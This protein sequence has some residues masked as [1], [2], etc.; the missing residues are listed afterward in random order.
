MKQTRKLGLL[1]A[2]FLLLASTNLVT[3][4][5]S[6]ITVGQE[7][8]SSFP[9]ITSAPTASFI[10]GV[11]STFEA[12]TTAQP[13]ASFTETGLLPNGVTLSLGGLLVGTPASGT[14]GVYPITIYASNGVGSPA[15]QNFTLTV[16]PIEMQTTS[17][18]AGEFGV[19]YS[20]TLNAVGGYPPYKWSLISGVKLPSGLKL[21]SK[22]GVISGVPKVV[23]TFS[24]SVQVAD[25]KTK[26]KPPTQDKTSETFTMTISPRSVLTFTNEPG[27]GQSGTALP[28]QP[29]VNVEN[30]SGTTVGSSTAAVT[31]SVATGAGSISCASNPVTAVDGV[32]S[33]A[34]C[35]ISG[36]AGT[37]T[38]SASSPGLLGAV[39]GKFTISAGTPN[40]LVF[41]T[42]PGSDSNGQDLSAQPTVTVEDASGN[43]VTSATNEIELSVAVGSGSLVCASD[44]VA[45]VDGIANFT[46]CRITGLV[47]QFILTAA[48][49]RLAN[50][51]SSPVMVTSG[52]AS[53]LVFSTE[54][55]TGQSGSALS[56][57]P[58]VTVEDASG[59][60]VANSS[61]PITLSVGSGAGS[62]TCSAN[63]VSAIDGIATFT[64]CSIA[65]SPGAYNLAASATGV[66]Q[67][68]ASPITV[69]GA[70]SQ[71]VFSTEPGNGQSGSALSVQPVVTVEDASGNTVTNSSL[72]ITLSVGS[73]AGSVT[74]SA[75]PVS[76]IDG[77]ATFTGCSIAGSPG[78]Y[79]LAASA[80]GVSQATASP[81]TVFG[82]ASQLVFST[83]PVPV[84]RVRSVRS[85]GRDRGRCQRQHGDELESADHTVRRLRGRLG[86]LLCQSRFGNR[87]DCH[88]HRMLNRGL[89][90]E[91]YI[92]R[93]SHRSGRKSI[94][95]FSVTVPPL[96]VTTSS[97]PGAS[98]GDAYSASLQA[99][100]GYGSYSWSVRSETL[101]R[102]VSL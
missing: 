67:A 66:S 63:P 47:G 46:G 24:F 79:N 98:Q 96:T 97:L 32:A 41:S 4:A 21:N 23:G 86:H 100:G 65:G 7:A 59:N 33:F 89:A 54:P 60:T 8:G 18:P 99:S 71:L 77:I 26:T 70:A 52:A 88:I 42:Q 82:A 74:C 72:P 35:A 92:G 15:T 31:L 95:S 27:A 40:R 38:L 43:K 85:A 39:S 58:V 10:V 78:A 80:T 53:Q 84:E 14:G 49:S 19:P 2:P 62:V 90:G 28:S 48:A 22:A 81:I 44:P 73:G 87:R 75:N 16:I 50:A 13:P 3:A 29:V 36:T 1:I 30:G 83:Q 20:T 76:A 93:L 34:G 6:P 11:S 68:T 5:A 102:A 94:H 64:G 37:Y 91:L 101:T 45:A 25:T 9:V 69:F 61:L 51:D 57:Q 55:G 56:V 17:L 12:S